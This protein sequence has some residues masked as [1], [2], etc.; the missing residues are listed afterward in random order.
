[1][2]NA[3]NDQEIYYKQ[4]NSN[5]EENAIGNNAQNSVLFFDIGTSFTN[6][7]KSAVLTV[8]IKCT[9]NDRLQVDFIVHIY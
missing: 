9:K 5:Q 7:Q 4:R 2:N 6:S 1:M 3:T 8:K